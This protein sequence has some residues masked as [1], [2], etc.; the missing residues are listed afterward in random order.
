MLPNSNWYIYNTTPALKVQG[1]FHKRSKKDYKKEWEVS[2]EI[3]LSRYNKEGKPKKSQER[4]CQNLNKTWAIPASW[5][6]NGDGENLMGY[7]LYQEL[8]AINNW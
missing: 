1:T 2:Y 6:P 8:W 5:H 7:N 4:G 3:V